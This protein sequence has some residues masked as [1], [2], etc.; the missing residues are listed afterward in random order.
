MAKAKEPLVALQQPIKEPAGNPPPLQQTEQDSPPPLSLPPEL[1]AAPPPVTPPPSAAPV[2]P[3]AS[4]RRLPIS[5]AQAEHIMSVL[6]KKVVGR[7]TLY[8]K[9]HPAKSAHLALNVEGFE[10]EGQPNPTIK[11]VLLVHQD[12]RRARANLDTTFAESVWAW[13]QLPHKP[14][15]RRPL[16]AIPSREELAKQSFRDRRRGK[17]P[18]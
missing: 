15:K 4:P 16:P 2:P 18:Q 1:Q 11:Q 17:K 3:P 14:E 7:V 9:F 6:S 13:L 5:L 10:T 8:D 12:G